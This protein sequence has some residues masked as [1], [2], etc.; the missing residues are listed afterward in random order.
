M[1]TVMVHSISKSASSTT[2]PVCGMTVDPG[3][4]AGSYEH[5]GET[6]FFCSGGCLQKFKANPAKYLSTTEV[7]PLLQIETIRPAPEAAAA[8][9]D[10]VCKMKV[11]PATAAGRYL[12]EG[13]P[14]YFCSR[15]CEEKFRANPAGYLSPKSEAVPV[16]PSASDVIYTCPMHPEIRQQGPGSCPR[17]GM[18]L[19]PEM[20]A[21]D[22][23]PNVELI[24]M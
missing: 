21:E 23:G 2:D 3:R 1:M 6:Y 10:P 20:A 8:Q 14:Y 13:V 18:A 11:M 24:E 22:E 4:A 17:C 19:E 16:E 15:R 5:G 9:I 12:H 7:P